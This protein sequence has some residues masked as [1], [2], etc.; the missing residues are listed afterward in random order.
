VA[1]SW[2]KPE[3]SRKSMPADASA[4]MAYSHDDYFKNLIQFAG[5]VLDVTG[6]AGAAHRRRQHLRR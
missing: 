3:L 2:L 4:G 5:V 6:Y 1:V